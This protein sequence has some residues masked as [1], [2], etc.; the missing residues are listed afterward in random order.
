MGAEFKLE[1]RQIAPKLK[2]HHGIVVAKKV[3]LTLDIAE[4]ITCFTA[5]QTLQRHCM[6]VALGMDYIHWWITPKWK[7]RH[8]NRVSRHLL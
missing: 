8:S 5:S 1:W 7:Q 3:V 4:T 2:Q 6:G